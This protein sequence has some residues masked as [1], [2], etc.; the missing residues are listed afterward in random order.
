MMDPRAPVFDTVP[1]KERM[2]LA[3]EMAWMN[4]AKGN[5]ERFGFWIGAWGT[6]RKESLQGCPN[7]FRALVKAAK[8]H[9]EEVE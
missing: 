9:I 1:V 4:L 5:F 7:P 3:E 2:D 8:A 6:L